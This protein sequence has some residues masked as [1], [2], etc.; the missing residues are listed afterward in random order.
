V[1]AFI[2]TM[3][4]GHRF[5]IRAEELRPNSDGYYEL[6]AALPNGDDPRATKQVVAV[7]DRGA[8]LS[9]VA[10]ECLIAVEEP[11]ENGTRAHVIAKTDPI[12]F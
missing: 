10:R 11:G 5:T 7:F 2:V 12:P 6:L 4:S 9:V 8:V 3:R 1:F